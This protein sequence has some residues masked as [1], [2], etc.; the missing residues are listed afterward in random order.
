MDYERGQGA[1]AVPGGV[2][3]PAGLLPPGGQAA[4]V[5]PQEI[6]KQGRRMDVKDV[7]ARERQL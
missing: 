7:C 5:Q 4:V 1:G 2:R 3:G 6:C